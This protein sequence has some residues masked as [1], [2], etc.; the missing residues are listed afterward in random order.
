MGDIRALHVRVSCEAILMHLDR[1]NSHKVGGN[2]VS[3]FAGRPSLGAIFNDHP[4]T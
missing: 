4:R 2:G 3:K 1:E